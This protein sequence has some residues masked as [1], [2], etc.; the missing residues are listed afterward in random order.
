MQDTEKQLLRVNQ[1]EQR[2][3][4]ECEHSRGKLAE[5]QRNEATLKTDLANAQRKVNKRTQKNITIG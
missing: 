3:K 4:Q 1:N 2:L 5:T